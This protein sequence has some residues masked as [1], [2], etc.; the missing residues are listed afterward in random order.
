MNL[1]LCIN[2][3]LTKKV[4]LLGINIRLNKI[5]WNQKNPFVGVFVYIEFV[6]I[7]ASTFSIFNCQLS[8]I[9]VLVLPYYLSYCY[10]DNGFYSFLSS[11]VQ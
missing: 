1:K 6:I 7:D 9:Q 4:F 11:S 2:K 8:G 10:K 5:G 3:E